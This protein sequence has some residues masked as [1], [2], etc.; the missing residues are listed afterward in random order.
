MPGLL[1]PASQETP[2][3]LIKSALLW[4][5]VAITI[6]AAVLAYR[7]ALGDSEG[8]QPAS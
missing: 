2:M 4:T 8:N 7:A 6:L 1:G 5:L 3:R